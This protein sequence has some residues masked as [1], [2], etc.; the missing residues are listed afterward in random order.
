[1]SWR[2]LEIVLSYGGGKKSESEYPGRDSNQLISRYK[3][4]KSLLT[5]LILFNVEWSQK[6]FCTACWNDWGKKRVWLPRGM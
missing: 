2:E 1:M 3:C 4:R 5:Y 6:C